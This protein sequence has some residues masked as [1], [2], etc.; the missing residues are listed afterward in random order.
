LIELYG[1]LDEKDYMEAI[2]RRFT[3][4]EPKIGKLANTTKVLFSSTKPKLP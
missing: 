2:F 1:A 3:Q 4:A